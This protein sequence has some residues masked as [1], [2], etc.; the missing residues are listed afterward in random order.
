MWSKI[1]KTKALVLRDSMLG[2]TGAGQKQTQ[3][4]PGVNLKP[5]PQNIST[6][7]IPQSRDCVCSTVVESLTLP[8][9]LGLIPSKVKN[10][11]KK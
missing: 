2:Q 5:K 7:E 9:V 10:Q 3:I 8:Q 1:L 6:N 11:Y 4:Q